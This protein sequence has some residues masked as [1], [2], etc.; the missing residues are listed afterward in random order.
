MKNYKVLVITG[1]SRGIGKEIAQYYLGKKDF[2]VFGCSRGDS[3]IN[4][5]N[6]IHCAL[7]VSNY[8]QVRKW[9]KGIKNKTGTI[10]Y[11]ICSAGLVKSTLLLPALPISIADELVDT[12]F[13]GTYYVCKE[14]SKIMIMNKF[15]RIVNISS[16]ATLLHD[17]GTSIYS[18]SKKAIEEFT[19]VLANELSSS[20]ITC[21]LLSPSLIPTECVKDFGDKWEAEVLAKL[22]S[23]KCS[24]YKEICNVLDFYF[25]PLSS[26]ITGQNI[27]MGIV[28]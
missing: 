8:E 27:F 15:G 17:P 12:M 7:D 18:S 10:D 5:E 26:C 25:H 28:S 13:K 4:H 19:K 24:T 16:F 14:V 22:T 1:T 3:F 11:L 6:Y 2:F 9:I 21:N 23:K 20:N